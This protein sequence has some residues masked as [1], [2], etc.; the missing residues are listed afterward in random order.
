MGVTIFVLPR[1]HAFGVESSSL[2]GNVYSR[3][4]P[5]PPNPSSMSWIGTKKSK[6]NVS[7]ESS[8]FA[9]FTRL[10]VLWKCFES[11]VVAS[12]QVS[13]YRNVGRMWIR[14]DRH[15][16]RVDNL[17]LHS[18]SLRASQKTNDLGSAEP[19]LRTN[20]F[21]NLNTSIT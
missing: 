21:H 11:L 2:R 15:R 4:A 19:V 10:H 17:T 5:A 9:G 3:Q 14:Q 7:R 1:I 20:P 18:Y 16:V 13:L 8:C 6:R 12:Q